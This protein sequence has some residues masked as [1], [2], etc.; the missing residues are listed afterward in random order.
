MGEFRKLFGPKASS[1]KRPRRW[2]SRLIQDAV[3]KGGDCETQAR[4]PAEEMRL[5]AQLVERADLGMSGGEV[6]EK[7]ADGAVVVTSRVRKERGAEES[8][9][10]GS[11]TGASGWKSGGRRLTRQSPEAGGCAGP[12]RA[13][14]CR[15]DVLPGCELDIQQRGLDMGMPHQLHEGGQT[16]AGAHH[17]G[18]KGVSKP[19]AGWRA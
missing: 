8:R 1:W 19:S 4:H 5:A 7:L 13:A 9:P 10:R 14:Y 2:M 16:D 6:G 18:G 17:V 12:R 11:K 15:V 3:A